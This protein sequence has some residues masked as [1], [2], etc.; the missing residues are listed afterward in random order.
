MVPSAARRG[1]AFIIAA[2]TLAIAAPCFG[3]S[4]DTRAAE[5][6]R[7][8]AEKAKNVAPYQRNWAERQLLGI[9]ETGLFSVASG[10]FVTFGDIKQGSSFAAGPGYGKTFESGAVVVTK[11][12][13]SVRSFKLGQLFAQSP[14]LAGG[15]LMINGRARWQDAP[16]LAVYPLGPA[17]PKTRSNYSEERT[18]FSG[19][20]LLSPVPFIR[21]GAGTAYEKYDTGGSSGG[22]HP[23]VD[24][25]FTPADMPGIGADPEY[26]HSF[27]TA[28][29]DSRAGPGFSRTGTQL[30]ASWHDYRQ[31]NEGPFSFR[32]IDGIARQFIPI[33]H[34]N[35]VLD[36]SVRVSTTDVD[37]GQEVPFFLMPDLGGSAELRGFSN[38]RFRDRHSILGTAE[39]RWYVQEYVEMAIFYDAGKVVP[40]RGDLDFTGLK[41]DVGI[42]LRFHS[43]RFTA[44]RFEVARSNEGLRLIFG[45]GPAI[46]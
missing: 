10:F 18:E 36:L 8:Q 16:E 44:L 19:Q 38:Y 21:L 34:G 25:A 1:L 17:S 35:W 28:G 22:R 5:I 45:F 33:L 43:P 41:S 12:V 40:R 3:Q 15:R 27:V 14:P 9:E 23:S 29:L 11:A 37:E 42:G 46:K 32:R 26:I 24:E 6:E 30:Q 39:Y 4:A 13:Y 31:Q 20:A 2:S 7:Q